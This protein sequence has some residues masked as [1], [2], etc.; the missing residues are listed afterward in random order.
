MDTGQYR[1]EW[2]HRIMRLPEVVWVTGLS[3][4]SVLRLEQQGRFPRSKQLGP[5]SKGWLSGDVWDWLDSRP[6]SGEGD[7]K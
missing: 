6:P 2:R 7:S 1:E 4:N 5:R 3:R